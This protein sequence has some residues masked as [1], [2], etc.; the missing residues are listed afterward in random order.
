MHNGEPHKVMVGRLLKKLKE[1][2][3][4]VEQDHRLVWRLTK[5]G[6]KV[7]KGLVATAN[8]SPFR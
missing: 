5:S 2:H 4:L 1:E 3:K 8:D 7:A 6:E